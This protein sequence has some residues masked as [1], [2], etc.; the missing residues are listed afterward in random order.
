MTNEIPLP[1]LLDA[2]R[3]DE[4]HL[5][6]S[7][8]DTATRRMG[9]ILDRPGGAVSDRGDDLGAPHN[10]AHKLTAKMRINSVDIAQTPTVRT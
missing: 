3:L 9:K 7:V 2:D 4:V 6:H 8:Q 1:V 5:S 10:L